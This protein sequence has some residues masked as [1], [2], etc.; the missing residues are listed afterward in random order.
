MAAPTFL[1]DLDEYVLI[2]VLCYLTVPDILRARQ[3]CLFQKI[4]YCMPLSTEP[5]ADVRCHESSFQ[6]ENTLDAD[7]TNA[8]GL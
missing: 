6:G 5:V 2:M 3:V 4:L 8:Q 1:S 7:A